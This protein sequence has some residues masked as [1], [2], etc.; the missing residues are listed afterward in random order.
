LLTRIFIRRENYVVKRIEQPADKVVHIVMQPT[1]KLVSYKPGQFIF[2]SFKQQGIS[3]EE[4]PFSVSSSPTT[5]YNDPDS[6]ELT[7][8]VKALGD[9]TG[10]LLGLKEGAGAEIEGAFGRFTNTRF[11]EPKQV[12]VA[13]G[14]GVT[15]FLS[16]AKS[17]AK[18]RAKGKGQSYEIHMFYVVRN[19]TELIEHSALQKLAN[20]EGLN[21]HYYTYISDA[22]NRL[23]SADYIS[24]AANG[25]SKT[26]VFICGP[27]PMMTSLKHQFIDFR[28]KKR[29]IHTE[30][31]SMS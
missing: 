10:T 19:E 3:P 15:P 8:T 1:N 20:I 28:V 26:D 11:K 6:I 23:I 7:I 24:K 4:H 30:E 29:N 18:Q 21:F 9:Y 25:L 13:G 22:Q 2:I 27:P 16:M 12:W 31:F 14:I 17:L 5:D